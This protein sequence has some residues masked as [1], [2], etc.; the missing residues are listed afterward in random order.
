MS[1][2]DQFESVFKAASKTPYTYEAIEIKTVLVVSDQV[3]EGHD[4][5]YEQLKTFLQV[6]DVEPTWQHLK[7]DGYNDIHELLNEVNKSAPDL[8][9]TYRNLKSN[10]YKWPYTLGSYLSVLTQE[11]DIP[12]LVT[13]HPKKEGKEWPKG[14]PKTVMAIT[15]HLTGDDRLVNYAVGFAPK[16][17]T[18]L[19]G[20]V[21]DEAEYKRVIEVISKISELDTDVAREKLL[22]QLLK[23]PT[24]YIESCRGVLQQEAPTVTLEAIVTLGHFLKDY[25]KHIEEHNVDLLVLNT[26]DDDQLAMHGLAYPIA[27]EFRTLPLLML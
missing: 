23:E 9:C 4:A 3:G 19:M 7:G 21:E 2:I 10:A 1:K 14:T 8:I 22:E 12:V 26:K 6:T 13:P 27:V 11:T 24:D 5:F 25:G 15:D 17:G 16:E 18:L 20:H